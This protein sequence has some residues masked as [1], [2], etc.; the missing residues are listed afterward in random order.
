MFFAWMN[1]KGETKQYAGTAIDVGGKH[2]NWKKK[3]EKCRE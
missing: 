3:N 1:Q 2:Q